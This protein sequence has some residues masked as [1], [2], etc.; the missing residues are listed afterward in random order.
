MIKLVYDLTYETKVPNLICDQCG[1][2]PDELYVYEGGEQLCEKCLKE[3]FCKI[4][5]TN[6]IERNCI[7]YY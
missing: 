3:C 5:Y 1:S 7:K 2:E 4:N 6:C